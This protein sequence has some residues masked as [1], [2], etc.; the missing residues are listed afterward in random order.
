MEKTGVSVDYVLNVFPT[1]TLPNHQSLVTGLYP[2]N[3]GLIDNE[4]FNP[5]NEKKY[6]GQSDAEWWSQST[7]IWILNQQQGHKS[8]VCF[9]P[10]Q[11]VR[12]KNMTPDYLPAKKYTRPYKRENK[13]DKEMPIKDRIKLVVDW[14]K[15]DDVTFV[16]LYADTIDEVAHQYAPDSNRKKY[17]NMIKNALKETDQMMKSLKDQLEKENL[18]SKVNV[19]M[20]G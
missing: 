13:G 4:F 20:I 10:G 17:K 15:N 16:A 1:S 7:P 2:E 11:R 3:H 14:L 5:E 8:G 6:Y 18:T 12:Y 19:I 9:W